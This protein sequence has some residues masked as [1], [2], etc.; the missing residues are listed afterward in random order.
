MLPALEGYLAFD[1]SLKTPAGIPHSPPP[2]RQSTAT[3]CYTLACTK[4]QT[5]GFGHSHRPAALV[6]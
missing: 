3:Q 4:G 6:V 5:V 1:E 2:P